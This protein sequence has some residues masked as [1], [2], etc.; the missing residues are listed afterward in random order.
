[1]QIRGVGLIIGT[2]FADNK[3]RDSPFPA[4]WGKYYYKLMITWAHSS[5]E[6]FSMSNHSLEPLKLKHSCAR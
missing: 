6:S 2:E 5:V 4:E 3:S 1:M